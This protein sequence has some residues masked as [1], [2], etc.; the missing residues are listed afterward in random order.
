MNPC[1]VLADVGESVI[2]G[3]IIIEYAC[4]DALG[5]EPH[6]AIEHHGRW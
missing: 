4:Y 5:S 1:K 2:G 6:L 3:I